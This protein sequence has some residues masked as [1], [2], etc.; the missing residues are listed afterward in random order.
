MKN[1][2]TLR[3]I[4]DTNH[5]IGHEFFLEYLFE[6]LKI[7]PVYL[8]GGRRCG[9]TS[10][11]YCLKEKY[12]NDNNIFLYWDMQSTR[13]EGLK[14][15]LEIINSEENNNFKFIKD[16]LRDYTE[17][18]IFLL[19]DEIEIL[20]GEKNKYLSKS[21]FLLL[22]SLVLEFD[23]F[24]ILIAT[25]IE[26][27]KAIYQNERGSG[28]L[29]I[30]S[31][32]YLKYPEIDSV[33]DFYDRYLM[34]NGFDKGLENKDVIEN[35]LDKLNGDID[36]NLKLIEKEIGL[37]PF[38]LQVVGQKI[39]DDIPYQFDNLDEIFKDTEENEIYSNIKNLFT[40]LDNKD[41]IDLL[42]QY[43]NIK[44]NNLEAWYL[45]KNGKKNGN[46]L[47][48]KISNLLQS[49]SSEFE[50]DLNNNEEQYIIN[51]KYYKKNPI[52]LSQAVK[53]DKFIEMFVLGM[54]E[55]KEGKVYS[56]K[57]WEDYYA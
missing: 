48:H 55:I 29:N 6:K 34:Q 33:M 25:P 37:N 1:P 18:K 31:T 41:I 14:R 40:Y 10:I 56:V 28:F 3:P 4:K 46:L 49:K 17:K 9:K 5:L 23:N 7:N 16:F 50:K 43:E 2:F 42:F 39:W 19:I 21:D 20:L 44:N 53:L 57:K 24:N 52:E 32:V 11:L 27:N 36:T 26:K 15:L 8:L 54:I 12:E 51:Y 22:R 45:V 38:F 13:D 30:F 35:F 47:S